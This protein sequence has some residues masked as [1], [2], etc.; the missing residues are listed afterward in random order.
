MPTCRAREPKAENVDFFS[1]IK[2]ALALGFRLA[3][4]NAH[5]RQAET[6]IA[7]YFEGKR[8]QFSVALDA[9]GSD[10][11]RGV[12]NALRAM[13]FGEVTH[14][15]DLAARLGA[16]NSVRAVAGANGANRIA[17]IIPCHGLSARMDR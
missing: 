2:E 3:G 17:I 9:S 7:E 13:E 16:P 6:E 8:R 12:W 11:Q 5:T 1:D 15:A 14:Y 4:E 10:F